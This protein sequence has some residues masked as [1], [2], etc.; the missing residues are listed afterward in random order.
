MLC[1]LIGRFVLHWIQRR[2]EDSDTHCHPVLLSESDGHIQDQPGRDDA[3]VLLQKEYT[4][5]IHCTSVE[6]L[7]H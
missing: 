2:E 3:H 4:L 7:T 6:T 5:I 1:V